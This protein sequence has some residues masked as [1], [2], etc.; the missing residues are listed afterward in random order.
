[1]AV[2]YTILQVMGKFYQIWSAW[3]GQMDRNVKKQKRK[4]KDLPHTTTKESKLSSE[5]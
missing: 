1:M 4:G 2:F 5:K 3:K